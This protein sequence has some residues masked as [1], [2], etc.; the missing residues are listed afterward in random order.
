[1]HKYNVDQYISLS[2]QAQHTIATDILQ[3][4]SIEACGVLLGFVDEFENWQVED[5]YPLPNTFNSPV[6]FEFDP[7][8]LLRV[9]LTY[10]GKIVGVYH[11]HPTGFARA[12]DTDRQNM[13]RV[14]IE[15]RIPWA[16]LIVCGPFGQTTTQQSLP[17]TKIIA[18]HHF[19]TDG[20]KMVALH[21]T[22][23][24]SETLSE[25]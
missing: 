20:L 6:Y 1:M 2:P 19:D 21:L 14:N 25:T 22:E 24:S 4:Q 16:W 10:P 15:E 23:S 8:D 11:S 5:A 3:R 13:H 18:Y 12:S 17:G 9:E 7:E